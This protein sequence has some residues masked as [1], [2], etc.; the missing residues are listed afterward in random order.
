MPIGLFP[1]TEVESVK[2]LTIYQ[3]IRETKQWPTHWTCSVYSPVFQERE[4]QECS[5]CGMVAL[6]PHTG[7]VMLQVMQQSLLPYMERE[8]W[9]V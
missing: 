3:Q 6:I 9:A 1:A 5:D 2:I 8:V 4:A 7:R